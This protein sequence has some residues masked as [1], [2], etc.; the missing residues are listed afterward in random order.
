[1]PILLVLVGLLLHL[2]MKW[3]L[4]LKSSKKQVLKF[5]FQLGEQQLQ[6]C[7]RLLKLNHFT[8]LIKLSMSLTL[9]GQLLLFNSSLINKTEVIMSVTLKKS[10]V[11]SERSTM[12]VRKIKPSF[13]LPK[14][15]L[16]SSEQIG[17]LSTS[18]DHHFWEIR[19]TKTTILNFQYHSLIGILSSKLGKLEVNIQIEA[20]QKYS[21]IKLQEKKQRS[22]LKQLKKC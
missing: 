11:T 10:T 22:Y 18:Y 17:R 21:K 19:F 4:T 20:I 9:Q 5:H 1:M 6:R 3:C 14:Q 16:R 13:L 2:Q 12:M 15:D 7:T 8:K